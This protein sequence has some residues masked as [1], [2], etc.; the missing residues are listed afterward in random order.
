MRPRLLIVTDRYPIDPGN[1]PAAWML[2]HLRSL[3][4]IADVEVVSL[5]RLFPRI[6]NLL[7]GGYD[8]QWFHRRNSLGAEER[9]FPHVV[10]HHRRC[11]TVPDALDWRVNPRL[12][13]LQQ[14]RWL[15]SRVEAFRPD[16]VLVHYLHASAPLARDAARE[17][18]IPLWIDENETIGGMPSE[19]Q[20]KLRD[21]ILAELA[22]ADVVIAQC[23]VQTAELRRLLPHGAIHCIPLGVTQDVAATEAPDPPHFELI[24]VSRLDLA[25]KNVDRLL[26]A[27]AMLR[28][29]HVPAVR[30]TIAGSGF[31]RPRLERLA[32]ELGIAEN[33]TFAGWLSPPV[34]RRTMRR[35]HAAV[36]PS[37]YESF[38][39]VAL[40]AAAAG[41]P[42]VACTRAGVVPDLAA[43]GAA[44][45]PVDTAA[46]EELASA[47]EEL[48]IRYSELQRQALEAR[49][50]LLERYSWE[51][52][53]RA[54]AS[55]LRAL[56]R[57]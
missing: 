25:G 56:R 26:H 10:V 57:K 5:V 46:P 3:E 48:Q 4:G 22:H 53:A 1:S 8:R 54:Y 29:R 9:P 13:R 45:L 20:Q 2:A 44:V 40:E 55:L 52:H 16:A 23:S 34:L 31:L 36:Q 51:A 6:K 38:G 14:Q 12:I 35:M 15:R 7:L 30:L 37:E 19:G 17:A 32:R 33:V 50:R 21:W 18:G 41:L 28:T 47:I 39:L 43:A 49:G 24:C 42:L 27:L 11:L